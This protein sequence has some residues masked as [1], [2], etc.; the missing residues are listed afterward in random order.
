MAYSR[1]RREQD[2]GRAEALEEAARELDLGRL[3]GGRSARPHERAH[4]RQGQAG[5]RRGQGGQDLLPVDA[6]RLSRRQRAEPAPASAA[7]PPLA[8]GRQAQLALPRRMGQARHDRR[9]QRRRRHHAPAVLDAVGHAGP[10][11]RAVRCQRHG[12]GRAHLLQR[13]SRRHRPGRAER[14]QGRRR[15]P[16]HVRGSQ[17]HVVGQCARRR[18][19][20]G[21]VPAG[22]RRDDRPPRALRAQ[23][24]CGRL[25]RSHARHGGRRPRGRGRRLRAA[26][27]RL[28][29]ADPGGQQEARPAPAGDELHRP[30]RQ[31]PAPAAMDHRDASSSRSSPTTT[32]SS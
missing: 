10:C 17:G 29:R 6:A 4:P 7:D 22:P 30:R 18:E 3:R 14:G 28:R 5:R 31:R 8:P 23:A 12:Q 16:R 32:P 11:R 25:R 15:R 19:H 21:Q 1:R 26:A 9:H 13:L 2:D 24:A 27:N 20:G